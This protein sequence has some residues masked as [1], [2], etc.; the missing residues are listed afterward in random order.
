ME[1]EKQINDYKR[2]LNIVNTKFECKQSE[3]ESLKKQIN[4]LKSF[5]RNLEAS[6]NETRV[7]KAKLELKNE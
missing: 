4:E 6:L 5:N 7:E 1:Y 2:K 3:V